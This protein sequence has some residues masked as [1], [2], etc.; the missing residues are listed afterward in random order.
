MSGA[1]VSEDGAPIQGVKI[2]AWLDATTDADGRFDLSNAPHNDALIFFQKEGFRPKTLIVRAQ[3]STVK[4]VLEDDRKTAWYVPW[5]LADNAN[6]SPDGY[7]L[8]FRLPEAAKL[9]KVKD[10]DYQEYLVS[11]QQDKRPLEL[12]WGPLVM[13]GQSIQD[14]M[15]RSASFEERS[16]HSS[17]GEVIGYDQ[18]GTT[19]D[20]SSWR[21]VD[22]S[23]LSGSA[24]YEGIPEEVP[25]TG[26]SIPPASYDKSIRPIAKPS[27]D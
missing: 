20:G 7:E 21:S 6:A 3:T 26:S 22:F 11:F 12:L 23:A 10:I 2:Y 25:T 16:I 1:V 4:V 19:R 17:S 5:Y 8:K 18:R 13:G 24:K 14:L 15:L 27:P 9:R